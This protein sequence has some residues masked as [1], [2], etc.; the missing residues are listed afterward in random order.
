MSIVDSTMMYGMRVSGDRYTPPTRNPTDAAPSDRAASWA[1]TAASAPRVIMI[2]YAG[3]A[4]GWSIGVQRT[5]V[6]TGMG[7]ST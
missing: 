2:G 7:R 6:A 3:S 4:H 5:A 1:C